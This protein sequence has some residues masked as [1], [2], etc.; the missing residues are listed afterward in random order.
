L[1]A[2]VMSDTEGAIYFES[3]DKGSAPQVESIICTHTAMGELIDAFRK[4]GFEVSDKEKAPESREA[5][6]GQ[7][8]EADFIHQSNLIERVTEK[9]FDELLGEVRAHSDQGHVGAWNLAKLM[10]HNRTPLTPALLFEMHRKLSDEQVNL[11]HP[12]EDQFIGSIR[13]VPVAIGGAV[14]PAPTRDEFEQMLKAFDQEL[15]NASRDDLDELLMLLADQH[16]RF[17]YMHPFVDANGRMGRLLV[18]YALE[19]F[20]YPPIVITDHD[21]HRYYKGFPEMDGNTKDMERF[22]TDKYGEYRND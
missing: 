14:K 12:I 6:P 21:K 1:L 2:S 22:F 9:N 15:A 3:F 19:Y 13:D 4:A 16:L 8:R 18:N 11:G 20:Q 10:G 17:E 5:T 7:I